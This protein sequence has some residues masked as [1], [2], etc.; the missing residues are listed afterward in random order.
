MNGQSHVKSVSGSKEEMEPRP[1]AGPTPEEMPE[2][3]D[4]DAQD[5]VER[6]KIRG[7]GD[8][9]VGFCDDDVSAFGRDLELLNPSAK[10]PG[11]NS[12]SEFMPEDVNPHG[13]GQEE[14]NCEP[15][16]GPTDQS[17]PDSFCLTG[18][19]ND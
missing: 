12:V 18:G 10:E 7:Q 13:L 19:A 4:Q 16:G 11:P 15:A 6:E 8:E 9:E 5:S 1:V 2:H 14:K 17:D 3:E